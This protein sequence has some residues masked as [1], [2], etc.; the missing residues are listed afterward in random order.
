MDR[1]DEYESS[2]QDRRYYPTQVELPKVGYSPNHRPYQSSSNP[3]SRSSSSSTYD[4][5]SRRYSQEYEESSGYVAVDPKTLDFDKLV[6]LLNPKFQ[7]EYLNRILAFLNSKNREICFPNIAPYKESFLM[8]LVTDKENLRNR[9]FNDICKCICREILRVLESNKNAY[10]LVH[11]YESGI[12]TKRVLVYQKV[13]YNSRQDGSERD[14]FKMPQSSDNKSRQSIASATSYSTEYSST[15]G[16]RR[17]STSKERSSPEMSKKQKSFKALVDSLSVPFIMSSL[18]SVLDFLEDPDRPSMQLDNVTSEEARFLKYTTVFPLKPA[19]RSTLPGAA[20][21]LA[22]Q[23]QRDLESWRVD[24]V[25]GSQ[26][27]HN[28]KT[29]TIKKRPKKQSAETPT[30]ERKK[31][32][33]HRRRR[34]R[35]SKAGSSPR[36]LFLKALS[37]SDGEDSPKPD[38]LDSARSQDRESNMNSSLDKSTSSNNATR[39][40]KL[41]KAIQFQKAGDPDDSTPT[42]QRTTERTTDHRTTDQ[43]DKGDRDSRRGRLQRALRDPVS[44]DVAVRIMNRM[45]WAGGALGLRGEGIT[46]PIMPAINIKSGAGLAY[47]PPRAASP[48]R[49]ERAR[50]SRRARTPLEFRKDVLESVLELLRGKDLERKEIDVANP[51]SKKEKAFITT[52]LAAI[53]ARKNMGLNSTTEKDLV[54]RIL[55]NMNNNRDLEID[56]SCSGDAR[57]ITL[58]KRSGA[59]TSNRTRRKRSSNPKV[60]EVLTPYKPDHITTP[61]DGQNVEYIAHKDIESLMAELVKTN[62][63]NSVQSL[64]GFAYRVMFLQKLQEFVKSNFSEKTYAFVGGLISMKNCNYVENLISGVNAKRNNSYSSDFENDL[65]EGLR[66]T[67]DCHLKFKYNATGTYQNLT[68]YKVYYTKRFINTSTMKEKKAE[69]E[70]N[71]NAIRNFYNARDEEYSSKKEDVVVLSDSEDSVI[72]LECKYDLIDDDDDDC[73]GKNYDDE[74]V[75]VEK[76]DDEVIDERIGELVDSL[77]DGTDQTDDLEEWR[78][79]DMTEVNLSS[80]RDLDRELVIGDVKSITSEQFN[81]GCNVPAE[82][83]ISSKVE[84]EVDETSFDTEIKNL[85]NLIMDMEGEECNEVVENKIPE[86]D[87]KTSEIVDKKTIA[88]YVEMIEEKSLD[89]TDASNNLQEIKTDTHGNEE[90]YEKDDIIITENSS[91]E[92]S[93]R[94]R[95]E[96][97]SS[98]IIEAKRAKILLDSNDHIFVAIVSSKEDTIIDRVIARKIQEEMLKSIAEKDQDLPLLKCHGITDNSLMYECFDNKSYSWLENVVKKVTLD[99]TTFIVIDSS[100]EVIRKR[101]NKI[102]MAV[103]TSSFVEE[104]PSSIFKRIELYNANIKTDNWVIL[105]DSK[106][107]DDL[108]FTVEVDSES[109]LTI[110]ESNYSLHTGIDKVEFS[111]ILI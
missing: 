68:F 27:R 58:L 99:D 86:D 53:N 37:I 83:K 103:K 94:S 70:H 40:P 33:R 46:E 22:R 104:P 63:V 19:L 18:Q 34:N 48:R 50:D 64:R 12:V 54:C 4:G 41:T 10:K 101:K 6:E 81:E 87:R 62:E 59:K 52:A 82:D 67:T 35:E 56:W 2:R 88:D 5:A 15:D 26:R 55:A 31:K 79:S 65:Y 108:V 42:D 100:E 95:S 109:F 30:L 28:L 8:K 43:R 91:P 96:S 17:R 29:V 38:K 75:V 16:D 78:D 90:N 74:C 23:M 106:L 89:V 1:Y 24:V 7:S 49:R 44:I 45:G 9:G 80:D 98:E 3:A 107:S 47:S 60:V 72:S 51:I 84:K 85:D 73:D 102:K 25:E 57:T 21:A 76:S 66:K 32:E 92:S 13:Y 110:C 36:D 39:H 61:T 93:K 111:E 97:E 20:A 105:D 71:N 69:D 77:L 11:S 14:I